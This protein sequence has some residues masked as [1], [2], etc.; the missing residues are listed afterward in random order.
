MQVE[1]ERESTG[2]TSNEYIVVGKSESRNKNESG[3]RRPRD[4]FF[5]LFLFSPQ[6]KSFTIFLSFPK[7]PSFRRYQGETLL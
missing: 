1:N 2:A 6:L 4:F 7:V 3:E 5:L